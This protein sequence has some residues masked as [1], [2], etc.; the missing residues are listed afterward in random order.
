MTDARHYEGS[1]RR[2]A[3]G[4]TYEFLL[5]GMSVFELEDSIGL[6]HTPIVM[7][8]RV[9]GRDMSAWGRINA[10][11]TSYALAIERHAVEKLRD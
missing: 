1:I 9:S 6:H 3:A 2:A 11:A 10:A 7:P 4:S 8:E 5:E